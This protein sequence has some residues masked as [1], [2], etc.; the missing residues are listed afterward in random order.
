[1]SHEERVRRI[2]VVEDD[3]AIRDLVER[4]LR[5]AGYDTRAAP[6]GLEA[7]GLLKA[8]VPYDL[9]L[10]DLLMPEMPGDE[11]VPRARALQPDLK[12]LYL[13]AYSDRLF[14]DRSAL[15]EAE[16][17]ID[18]PIT[19]DGLRQAVSLALYGHL[20]GPDRGGPREQTGR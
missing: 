13:T 8:D 4:V 1:V 19:I 9:L 5:E 12:V 15:W 6:N 16:A 18:K 14:A 20:R 3:D 11:L 10:T 2:L 7:L 17:F